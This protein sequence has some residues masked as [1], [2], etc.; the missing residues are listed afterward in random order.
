MPRR[1]AALL[2]VIFCIWLGMVCAAD[3]PAQGRSGPSISWERQAVAITDDLHRG[4]FVDERNGWLLT[5]STGVVLRTTDGG[6]HWLIQSRLEAGYLESIFFADKKHGWICGDNGRIYRTEDGGQSWR[7]VGEKRP[8]LA[9]SAVHF[10][11]R[12]QGLLAG[13]R[14]Q[15]RQSVLFEST[16]GGRSWQ[17]AS[18]KVSGTGLSG[19]ITFINRRVGFIAGFNSLWRTSDGGGSWHPFRLDQGTVVRDITFRNEATGIAV[20]H[21][22]LVLSTTDQGKNW[23]PAASFTAGLLRSVIFTG[24]ASG[25]IAGDTDSSGSSLWQTGDGGSNWQKVE[26]EFPDIHQIIR[27][28]QRLYLIG[29]SGTVLSRRL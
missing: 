8:E 16:D 5:H 21:K 28:R 1:T 4:F 23:Q 3:S 20:G 15:P 12:R 18:A 29:D 24:T 6:R 7:Q 2:R 13:M 27:T 26:G 25:L 11:N 19:A 17:D 10:F 22:G 14:I 9:F